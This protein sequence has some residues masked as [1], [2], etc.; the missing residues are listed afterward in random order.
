[1]WSPGEFDYCTNNLAIHNILSDLSF[2]FFDPV[3]ETDRL[4]G[5]VGEK[6]PLLDE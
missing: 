2:G 1:M 5:N 4:S 6:L 3:D